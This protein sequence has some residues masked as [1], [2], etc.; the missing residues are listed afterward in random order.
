MNVLLG[1]PEGD[2]PTLRGPDLFAPLAQSLRV[3]FL[4]SKPTI[5]LNRKWGSLILK[6]GGHCEPHFPS[7]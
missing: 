1:E 4:V 2:T 7:S 3:R 5:E 6:T